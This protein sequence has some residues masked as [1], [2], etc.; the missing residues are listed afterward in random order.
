MEA[1][2]FARENLAPIAQEQ[3]GGQ[4]LEELEGRHEPF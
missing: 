2:E 4:F 3:A 1:I